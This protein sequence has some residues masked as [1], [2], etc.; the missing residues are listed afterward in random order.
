MNEQKTAL[1]ERRLGDGLN[2]LIDAGADAPASAVTV[3]QVMAEGREIRRRRR[4]TAFA[5]C[6]VLIAATALTAGA[7]AAAGPADVGP[8]TRGTTS[9]ATPVTGTDPLA[10]NVAFGWLPTEMTSEY[11][12]EQSVDGVRFAPK[13]DQNQILSTEWGPGTS[14][15]QAWSLGGTYLY[16]FLTDPGDSFDPSAARLTPAGTVQGHQAWWSQTPGSSVAAI[17]KRLILTWQYSPHVWAT[18]DYSYGDTDATAAAM[19][20]KV[21]AALQIGTPHAYALPFRLKA[22]PAGMHVDTVRID[23]DQQQNPRNGDAALKL[24][25]TSPCSSGGIVVSEYIG[26]WQRPSTFTLPEDPALDPFTGKLPPGFSGQP[27][28]G[29]DI[30]GQQ[31]SVTGTATGATLTFQIGDEDVTFEALGKE[32]TAIGGQSGLAAFARTVTWLNAAPS[33]WTTAVVG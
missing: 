15:V 21:A 10:P 4:N 26:A 14:G 12:V 6:A 31:A 24:C 19:V 9:P 3:A 7:I 25:L 28:H 18:V 29:V 16:A 5:I 11:E 17:E 13:V 1:W 30:N 20:L 33:N 2:T 27:F 23:L 32:Y 22:I 8:P